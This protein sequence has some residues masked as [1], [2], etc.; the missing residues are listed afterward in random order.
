MPYDGAIPCYAGGRWGTVEGVIAPVRNSSPLTP[1]ED[2]RLELERVSRLLAWLVM[3]KFCGYTLAMVLA[4][5][6]STSR[7]AQSPTAPEVDQWVRQQGRPIEVELRPAA[8]ASRFT[9]RRGGRLLS[10][11]S[12][13]ALVAVGGAT[14]RFDRGEIE[15]FQ[16]RHRG[17]GALEGLAWGVGLGVVSGMALALLQGDAK[18]VGDCGYPCTTG[19]KLQFWGPVFGVVG[20][21]AGAATGALLGHRQRLAFTW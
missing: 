18:N 12:S 3:L 8:D 6:C 10:L 19:E 7:L 20:G 2:R 17:R 15:A 11:E 4:A 21:A 13:A 1:N 9:L 14:L 16:A 5:G